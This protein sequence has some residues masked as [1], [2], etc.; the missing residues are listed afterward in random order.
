MEN[1]ITK[2]QENDALQKIREIIESIGGMDSYIGIALDGC[3]EIAADNIRND[4]AESMKQRAEDAEKRASNEAERAN[5]LSEQLCAAQR[6]V[7][8]LS[9]KL[10]EELEWTD[11]ELNGNVLQED[12]SKLLENCSASE[13]MDEDA[14]K[15]LLA[16]SFGFEKERITIIYSVAK[17]Q[18][19]RHRQLRVVGK[20]ERCPLYFSSDWNY[21]RFDC[22]R[23][24]YELNNGH[25]Q[26]FLQ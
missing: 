8:R 15:Q 21:I 10:E 25:L 22:G 18:V 6:E 26:F 11:Y 9:A 19:S 5:S 2:Q 4:F 14:A 13:H 3:L 1:M 12:Y 24:S 17:Y 16:E 20:Y 7:E 23:A